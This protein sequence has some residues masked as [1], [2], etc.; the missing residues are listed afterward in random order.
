MD[1][2]AY[3]RDSN[4]GRRH[5]NLSGTECPVRRIGAGAFENVSSTGVRARQRSLGVETLSDTLSLRSPLRTRRPRRGRSDRL[6]FLCRPIRPVE[7][8]V[9]P[10]RRLLQV[11]LAT[12]TGPRASSSWN[13][14]RADP[15]RPP[16]SRTSRLHDL[17]GDGDPGRRHRCSR[18]ESSG[19][20]SMTARGGFG[21]ERLD[22]ALGGGAPSLTPARDRRSRPRR[23]TNDSGGGSPPATRRESVMDVFGYEGKRLFLVRADPRRR[24]PPACAAVGTGGLRRGRGRPR[25]PRSRDH[26]RLGAIL[27]QVNQPGSHPCRPRSRIARGI[28]LATGDG[29]AQAIVL[30]L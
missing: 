9:T 7:I 11:R 16:G 3:E 21:N 5:S 27:R 29:P 10:P 8:P 26:E 19:R 14:P 6:Y 23:G 13:G 20:T 12:S 18:T 25:R 4:G 17:D 30:D 15:G 22:Q 2:V 28:P 1:L 24:S